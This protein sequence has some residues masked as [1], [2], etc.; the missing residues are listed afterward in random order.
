MTKNI[1]KVITTGSSE[2]NFK[3]YLTNI[4]NKKDILSNY[5]I[6]NVNNKISLEKHL[7]TAAATTKTKKTAI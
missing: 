1:I 3:K 5:Q 2:M 7:L 6:I 4:L